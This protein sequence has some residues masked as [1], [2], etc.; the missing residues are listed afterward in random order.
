MSKSNR[1]HGGFLESRRGGFHRAVELEDAA[2]GTLD[3]DKLGNSRLRVRLYFRGKTKCSDLLGKLSNG[4]AGTQL[5]TDVTQ[6]LLASRTE[7]DVVLVIAD[8]QEDRSVVAFRRLGQSDGFEIVLLRPFNVRRGQCDVSKPKYLRVE[9]L[10]MF[11]PALLVLE[12]GPSGERRLDA[13]W[14]HGQLAQASAGRVGEGVGKG[15]RGWRKRAFTRPQRRI[16]SLHQNDFNTG[17]LGEGEDGIRRPVSARDM[18]SVEGDLF[19]QRETDCLDD[20]AFELVLR[21]VWID[22]EPE[23]G[24]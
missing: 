12:S 11:P 4:N 5:K 3:L 23:I 8:R 20:A 24:R 1:R 19:L 16:A 14:R 17:D 13:F 22:G 21:A 2:A 10:H 15:S 18:A 9:F 7:H 6:R